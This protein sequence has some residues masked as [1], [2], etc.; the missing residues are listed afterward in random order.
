MNFQVPL[1]T[2]MRP[3]TISAYIG[4]RHL[5]ADG[6]PLYQAITQGQLHSM[7]FWGP[8]GSGKTTLAM[9]LA[10]AIDAE[11]QSLSAVFSGVK[12]I[13]QVVAAAE[14]AHKTTVLFIDEIHRF[15]KAQQDAFLPYIENGRII[16][17][18]ATTENPSFELNNALLSRCQVYVLKPLSNEELNQIIKQALDDKDNGF[19]GTFNLPE[20]C[21]Q[22]LVDAADG[23]ARRCLQNLDILHQLSDDQPITIEL[24]K[25]ALSQ[26]LGRYDK[27]GEAFYDFI[28]VLHKAIRGSDP[29]A[30]L[31]WFCRMLQGGCDPLYIGRR[32]IRL[33]SEDIGNA[34][35]RALRITLDAVEAFERLGSPEGE[36]AIAQAITYC[37][38]AAKSNSVYN[39]YKQAAH[40]ARDHGSRE[41]PLRFRNSVTKLMKNLDY[42]KAYR[43]AHDEPYAYAAGET[44]FPDDLP[45]QKFYHPVDRG[46]EIKIQEKLAFLKQLDKAK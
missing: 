23:D 34:D 9:L 42:G 7:V 13:R 35:P 10:Q 41:V 18:G 28:S 12:D 8:P 26:A 5:L 15:N 33:A 46:L 32:L 21:C 39:A 45:P 24:V 37:A 29:D 17:I 36:L 6:K 16:L 43:Y 44:Y 27:Q 22:L 40:Y 14:V 19:G 2:R 25:A 31:Y 30:A 4:Q 3:Q 20:D 11:F 38:C 1:A